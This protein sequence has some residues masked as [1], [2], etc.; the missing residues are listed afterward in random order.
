MV[1]V[2]V[3]V[4]AAIGWAI[5]SRDDPDHSR[6]PPATFTD[7]QLAPLDEEERALLRWMADT[8][9]EWRGL[10]LAAADFESASAQRDIRNLERSCRRITDAAELLEGRLPAPDADV[11]RDLRQALASYAI[12]GDA[13][14]AAARGEVDQI[15]A[16]GTA[17]DEG[18]A[19]FIHA[20]DRFAEVECP[21]G[22]T[23]IGLEP[24]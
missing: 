20:A 10:A 1:F 2:F 15:E 5:T 8:A 12:G 3:V 22:T 4:L 14:R 16:M 17:F 19:A 21:D 24:C 23:T 6:P 7:A 13:C 18:D 11:D 9:P